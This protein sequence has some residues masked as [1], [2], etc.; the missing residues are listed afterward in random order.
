MAQVNTC[1]RCGKI[2]RDGAFKRNFLH[3]YSLAGKLIP[4]KKPFSVQ[5]KDIDLCGECND[6]FIDWLNSGKEENN[7]ER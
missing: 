5:E 1:D 2:I 6:S 4:F 7:E 3:R